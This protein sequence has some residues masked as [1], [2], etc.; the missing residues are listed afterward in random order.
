MGFSGE[1]VFGRSERPLIEAPVFGG[2]QEDDEGGIT[3]WWPRPGG[4]QMWQFHGTLPDGAEDVLRAV[5]EWTGAPACVASVHDSDV[6][7]VSG[8]EPGGDEWDVWLNLPIAAEMLDRPLAE[9]DASV[10]IGARKALSWARSAGVGDGADVTV[11]E[12]V[13]RSQET[14]AEEL[15]D[16]LLDRLGFP[17]AVDPEAG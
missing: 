15:F 1:L 16:T 17:A 10:P 8:L 4:W 14:F 12:K 6:A 13:L 7:L 5:V 9:L 2:A 11:I 3:A